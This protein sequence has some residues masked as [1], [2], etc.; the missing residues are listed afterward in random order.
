[1]RSHKV[2]V[3]SCR[4]IPQTNLSVN[5][6]SFDKAIEGVSASA[7]P[8]VRVAEVLSALSF[9]L[10]LTG[11]QPPG[12]AVRSCVIG[13][14]L[15]HEMDLPLD[16]RS[17][18]YYALLMKDAG[19]SKNASKMMQLLGTDD[20]AGKRDAVAI[21]WTRMGWESIHYA[22][23]HAKTG[24]PFPERMRALCLMA[25]DQKQNA[26]ILHQMRC[27]RGADICQPHRSPG[28]RSQGDPLPQRTL[29]WTR[30]A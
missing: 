13:M 11:G 18:L 4:T 3:A 5:I 28:C 10:D 22:L 23:R 9:A 1:L 27:E 29:E 8:K 15:G 20:I 21:D 7:A 6:R 19:C 14:H 2:S 26:K 30:P 16:A 17:N 12:H 25:L 24:A